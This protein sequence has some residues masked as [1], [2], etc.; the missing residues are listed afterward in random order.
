MHNQLTLFS[1]KI[2]RRKFR[3]MILWSRYLTTTSTLLLDCG[4][5]PSIDDWLDGFEIARSLNIEI[6]MIVESK[7]A[8][9]II[10]AKHSAMS[11]PHRRIL[12]F[13][14]VHCSHGAPKGQTEKGGRDNECSCLNT[15]VYW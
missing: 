9:G 15:L 11:L 10:P 2:F 7:S 4:G 12:Q 13:Q 8:Y 14:H 3:T 5:T 1:A 6:R